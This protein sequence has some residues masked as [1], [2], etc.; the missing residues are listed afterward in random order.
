MF[1]TLA[2]A[3]SEKK[4]RHKVVLHSYYFN[5]GDPRTS[6]QYH[7][8]THTHT[9]TYA[10]FHCTITQANN[11][12]YQEHTMECNHS[13]TL[14]MSHHITHALL[15]CFLLWSRNSSKMHNA[16]PNA[17]SSISPIHHSTW[18]MYLVPHTS[19]NL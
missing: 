4:V 11:T 5:T 16:S 14:P 17:L 7:T 6:E 13:C 10:L 18:I 1:Y 19:I 8:H 15:P 2:H 9:H 3:V 12:L